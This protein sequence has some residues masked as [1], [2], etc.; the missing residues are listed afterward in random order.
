MEYKLITKDEEAALNLPN[1]PF[2][3]YGKLVVSLN[4]KQWTYKEEL[5][6]QVEEQ[7]FPEE[8]YIYEEIVEKGFAIGAFQDSKCVALAIFENHWNEYM[9]LADLKVTKEYRR[10]GHGQELIKQG[11]IE[12]QSLGY[13]GLFTIGQDN[14]LGACKF[15]LN[16]G[17]EIGGF[18]NRD[19][20]FTQQEGKSDIYF[21]LNEMR[22]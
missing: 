11:F 1:E 5:F 6:E 16:Q 20:D 8:N 14:N 9:Y 4:N 18:N 15:Y 2:E 22:N 3:L 7:T 17:F 19:Y 12:A 13:K 10:F 21:Y